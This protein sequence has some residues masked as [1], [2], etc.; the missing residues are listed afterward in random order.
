MFEV[1]GRMSCVAAHGVSEWA[2]EPSSPPAAGADQVG[3]VRRCPQLG[4][5]P[6]C[7]PSVGWFV[8]AAALLLT[9]SGCGGG[10]TVSMGGPGDDA[11]EASLLDKWQRFEDGAPTLRM[12][13]AQVSEAWRSAARTSAHRVFRAGPVSVGSD[14]GPDNP[15]ATDPVFPAGA[16]ACAPGECGVDPRPGSIWAFAPVLEHRGIPVAE[17]TSRFT[18]TR[19]L[20][21]G[22]EA[23][24]RQ[25]ELFDS[26]TYGGWLDRTHFNVS[27]TRWCTV[28]S[29]GCSETD[30]IDPVYAGGGVLGFMAGSYSGTAPTGTGSTTWSGIMIGME[31]LA[32]DLLQRERPAVFL[33]NA[34]VTIE[35]LAAPDADVSFTGIHNV[36]EGT[37]HRDM[38]WEDLPIEDGLFGS[39]SSESGEEHPD[40]LVG[41]FTGPRHGEAGG[42]FRR[43][44]IAGAFGAA[45]QP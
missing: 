36:T 6:S 26:L 22:G 5:C 1:S 33:G 14:P 20:E 25:T 7:I 44:G 10:G 17:F 21:A 11:S 12:T 8:A 40:Y 28:G 42:T 15:V 2:V 32:P 24:D 38:H 41:M 18:E 39:V 16:E 13:D 27:V 43:N 35:D 29:A 9:L 31:D 45:R 23:S 3:D 4:S 19:I 30:D 37:R 34:R